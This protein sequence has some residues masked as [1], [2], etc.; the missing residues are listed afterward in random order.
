MT[1]SRR[2]EK[3]SPMSVTAAATG[4]VAAS[5]DDKV[6]VSVFLA[7]GVASLGTSVS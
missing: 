5:S 4:F 6:D 3:W 1:I 2:A 7:V